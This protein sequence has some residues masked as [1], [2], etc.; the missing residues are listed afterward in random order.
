[1][2]E[3]ICYAI[4]ARHRRM[5]KPRSENPYASTMK[6][7]LPIRWRTRSMLEWF[8]GWDDQDADLAM[9]MS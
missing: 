6:G 9:E 2:V 1:M 5:N 8:H 4:G 7:L 3:S